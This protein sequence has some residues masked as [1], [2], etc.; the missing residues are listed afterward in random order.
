MGAF[1]GRGSWVSS[2]NKVL[3][4]PNRKIA[5]KSMCKIYRGNAI[6]MFKI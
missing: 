3:K 4:S 1:Y 5:D 6:N 2:E